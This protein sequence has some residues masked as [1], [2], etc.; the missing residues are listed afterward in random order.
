MD[1][2]HIP[3]SVRPDP[4]LGYYS[5]FSTAETLA[6][7]TVG[8]YLMSLDKT[9]ADDLPESKMLDN[10]HWLLHETPDFSTANQSQ[11]ADILNILHDS[12]NLILKVEL[13]TS[14]FFDNPDCGK[15]EFK[16]STENDMSYV[17]NK[18]NMSQNNCCEVCSYPLKS[19]MIPVVLLKIPKITDSLEVIKT[20]YL[21]KNV[22]ELSKKFEH[23]ELLLSRQRTTKTK[24]NDFNI[25]NDFSNY[26]SLLIERARSTN[27]DF[28]YL[29]SHNTTQALVGMLA[30]SELCDKED[31][32]ADKKDHLA[33]GQLLQIHALPKLSFVDGGGQISE[34]SIES[35]R[36]HSISPGAIRFVLMQGLRSNNQHLS[37]PSREFSMV[38]TKITS[39]RT[40]NIIIQ[41]ISR[42]LEHGNTPLPATIPNR[43]VLNQCLKEL[44]APNS[45]LSICLKNPIVC[46]I[47][48]T[49]LD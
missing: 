44:S 13:V 23:Q 3:M 26:I 1:V 10:L 11:E 8:N 20:P 43:Q 21:K 18:H 16:A 36:E 35:L 45:K 47:I 40:N 27:K 42:V 37:I 6:A 2:G 46:Q 49:I 12:G 48:K 24:W 29:A 41:N 25:D 4:P 33:N 19:S 38:N 28:V 15:T 22:T 5:F 31:F 32:S 30:I 39:E 34:V 9:T 17:G 14:C 7:T